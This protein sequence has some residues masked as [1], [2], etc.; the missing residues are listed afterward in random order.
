MKRRMLY[1]AAVLGLLAG[2]R[3][4][5][6]QTPSPM[7]PTLYSFPGSVTGT[8]SAASSGIAAA[9]RWLSDEPF[10]NP[11]MPP[12]RGVSLSPLLQ[13]VSRQDL[14]AGNRQLDESPSF[15]F[16]G[17]WA[18]YAVRRITVAV[19]GWQPV[20]R[21]ED[22]AFIRGE[23]GT[24]PAVIAS[25]STQRESR[26]GLA[27]AVPIGTQVRAGVA[28][29]WTRRDDD[30]QYTERSGDPGSGTR[31][32]TLTGDGFGFA[33]G[34]RGFFPVFGSHSLEVGAAFHA[35]PALDLTGD[36]TLSLLTGDSTA[37]YAVRRGSGSEYGAA[38]AI[39]LSPAVRMML[40]AGGRSELAYDPAAGSAPAV[41]GY[42][43]PWGGA[44]A[45]A[46]SQWSLGFEYAEPDVPLQVRGGFGQ[47]VQSGVPE[48]RAATYAIGF[49][50][51]ID[52]DL[53]LDLGAMRR[54]FERAGKATSYDDRVVATVGVRF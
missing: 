20:L 29:E 35:I 40:Q 24:P 17:G 7:D 31:E 33:L 1:L 25:I 47:E 53:T 30:F 19:Y 45:G 44:T 15:D 34:A 6:S 39:S 46:A 13:R 43:P 28:G 8:T 11:A 51:R 36:Q 9:D 14:R 22:L 54:G 52:R 4:A 18:A 48:P 16:S 10:L 42:T 38:V 32:A 3:P 50:W 23:E 2:T 27:L 26:A 49:G 5:L 41:V 37:S 12:T 21:R